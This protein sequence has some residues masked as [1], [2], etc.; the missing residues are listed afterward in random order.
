MYIYKLFFLFLSTI[1]LFFYVGHI[2]RQIISLHIAKYNSFSDVFVTSIIGLSTTIISFALLKSMGTSI[3][4]I[5]VL[6]MIAYLK[7]KKQKLTFRISISLKMNTEIILYTTFIFLFTFVY[8]LLFTYDFR[9][10]TTV[11]AFPDFH[12]YSDIA[13]GL[14]KTGVENRHNRMFDFY[15]PTDGFLYH[16]FDSWLVA[17]IST[18]SRVNTFDVQMIIVYPLF[19]FLT[20]LGAASIIELKKMKTL[21]TVLFSI[22]LMFGLSVNFMTNLN[23]S[24]LDFWGFGIT[25]SS[26]SGMKLLCIY[27]F[28]LLALFFLLKKRNLEFVIIL[29]VTSLIYNIL[30]IWVLSG[31]FFTGILLLFHEKR[32]TGSLITPTIK[33]YIF[34]F[35]TFI[36]ALPIYKFLLVSNSASVN[37]T[38]IYYL[39]N[40]KSFLIIFVEN[41]IKN[42]LGYL[43]IILLLL[44]TLKKIKFK[45]L[46]IQILFCFFLGGFLSTTFVITLFHGSANFNQALNNFM[47][48]FALSMFLVC[49]Y[50][51]P[52]SWTKYIFLL[53]VSFGMANTYTNF[54]NQ[55]TTKT[56]TEKYLEIV[57]NTIQPTE[58]FLLC[59]PKNEHW[60][61]YDV[62]EF[63]SKLP[64]NC[65]GFNMS[66][67]TK[68]RYN[69]M[70]PYII[71]CKSKHKAINYSTLSEYLTIENVQYIFS[72]D[73]ESFPTELYTTYKLKTIDKNTKECFFIRK[74]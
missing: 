69:T 32:K 60:F 63:S 21:F 58:K 1:V 25:P 50:Y 22:V 12:F 7:I 54:K 9:T 34:I 11:L 18:I 46:S 17:F 55:K 4:S 52:A 6:L 65:S 73:F 31:L 5:I 24:F 26:Y 45:E 36:L 71:W 67:D 72:L 37:E 28:V 19:F 68:S 64:D 47:P 23:F 13:R 66:L 61:C 59:N 8:W 27:P 57:L 33:Q 48:H 30:L 15:I 43:S 2:L 44:L 56:Y 38:E 53:L 39:T 20:I 40:V 16:Y 10:D 35:G 49:F 62:A 41:S 14:I 42:S 3:F 70:S 29:L 51:I 74:Q